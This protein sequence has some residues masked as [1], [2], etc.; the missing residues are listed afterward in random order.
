MPECALYERCRHKWRQIKLFPHKLGKI[1]KIDM[2]R[3]GK[4]CTK[5]TPKLLQIAVERELIGAKGS[6]KVS[7]I[8]EMKI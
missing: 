8:A 1:S 7:K 5:P 2:A 3:G 4:I 6:S